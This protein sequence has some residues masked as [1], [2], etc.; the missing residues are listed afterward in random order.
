MTIALAGGKRYR[1]R[2]DEPMSRWIVALLSLVLLPACTDDNPTLWIDLITDLRP[3]VDFTAATI[4]VEPVNAGVAETRQF[5]FRGESEFSTGVRIASLSL[6]PNDYQVTLTLLNA[7]ATAA[8]Q[9]ALVVVSGDRVMTVVISRDCVDVTC[10]MAA[11]PGATSCLGGRCVDPECVVVEAECTLECT[12]ASECD[13]VGCASAVCSAGTCLYYEDDDRCAGGRCDIV[14]GCIEGSIDAGSDGGVIMDGGPVG[15]D[16]GPDV[17]T[18]A[19]MVMPIFDGGSDAGPVA[20]PE[21]WPDPGAMCD[22]QDSTG[23][24]GSRTCTPDPRTP[25]TTFCQPTGGREVGESCGG[26]RACQ[27][28]LIC[29]AAIDGTN[30]RCQEQCAVGASCTCSSLTDACFGLV[31]TSYGVCRSPCDP[32]ANTGCSEGNK[33]VHSAYGE[34]C[35]QPTGNAGPEEACTIFTGCAPGGYCIRWNGT[36]QCLPVCLLADSACTCRADGTSD[37]Y[38]FCVP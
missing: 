26:T 33:C 13:S 30:P 11:D 15:T 24:G 37:V 38:G 28:G 25:G 27:R 3:G 22:P 19:G 4:R 35:E 17:G 12:N 16:A 9:E 5:L 6:P 36:T 32:I 8:S 2:Y 20:C 31:G 21:R 7:G 14:L 1:F 34:S 29:Q 18:D 23:C 10:P